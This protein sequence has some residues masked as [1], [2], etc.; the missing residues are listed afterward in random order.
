M[1]GGIPIELILFTMCALIGE[2]Y[3]CDETWII[4]YYPQESDVFE[5]CY[6]GVKEFHFAIAGC[7][8]FDN[9]RGHWMIFG[10]DINERSHTGQSVFLHEIKHMKC[11]CNFHANPPEPPRR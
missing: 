5:Y 10:K 8:V 7:A 9:N 1:A 6:P 11:L 3:D 4:F 2:G